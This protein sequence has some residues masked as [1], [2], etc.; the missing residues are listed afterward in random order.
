MWRFIH[1]P[2]FWAS[3]VAG[4]VGVWLLG[5]ETERVEVYPT[6]D[7]VDRLMYRDKANACLRF[8][9]RRVPCPGS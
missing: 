1:W 9:E 5:P 2:V 7:N 8:E 4:L 6:P 3:F